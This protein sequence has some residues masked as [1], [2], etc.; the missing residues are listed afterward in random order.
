MKNDKKLNNTDG[1]KL[2]TTTELLDIISEII[3]CDILKKMAGEKGGFEC[4]K[5]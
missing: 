4:Q 3:A 2:Y 1:K 5:I